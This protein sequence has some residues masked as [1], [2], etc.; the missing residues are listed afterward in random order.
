[1]KRGD[2]MK[3]NPEKLEIA[4]CRNEMS[5]KKLS[6]SSGISRCSISGYKSGKRKPTLKSIGKIANAIEIDVL[7]LLETKKE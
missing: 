5:V 2:K 3:F 6:E 4:M 1:M 7:E